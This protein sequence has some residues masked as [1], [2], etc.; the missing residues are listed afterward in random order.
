MDYSFKYFIAKIVFDVIMDAST[1]D[2]VESG[3]PILD[4]GT[5]QEEEVPAN[6]PQPSGKE[7]QYSKVVFINEKLLIIKTCLNLTFLNNY[8]SKS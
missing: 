6:V 3:H 8:C 4:E 7:H 2:N 5:R 1:P